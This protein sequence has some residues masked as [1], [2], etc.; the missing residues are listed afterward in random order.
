MENFVRAFQKGS[1]K[2][3]DLGEVKTNSITDDDLEGMVNFK[4]GGEHITVEEVDDENPI[5]KEDRNRLSQDLR[6]RHLQMIAICGVFGTGIF[7]SSGTVYSLTGAGGCFLAYALVAVVVGINQVAIAEVAALMPTSSAVVR[8]LE[9][10][11]DPA[12]GF[13]YGWI[14]WWGASMPG[15][16]SAAAV[17]V[18]YWTDINGAAWISIIIVLSFASNAYSMRVYGE[19]EFFFAILKLSLLLGLIIVSI[20]ITSGGGPNHEAIGFRYWRD[21]DAFLPFLTTGSLGRFAAFWKSLSSVV[22]SYGGVQSV[23]TLAS[24]VRYPR[25]SVFK[26]CKRIFFRVTILMILAAF[27]LTLI[28]SPEDKNI[29][30]GSGNAKS[31]PFV[32]AIKNAGI[33]ALPHIVNAVVLT[34]AFS[35]GNN[36]VVQGTRCLFAMAVKGQAPK[37]FLK[38]TKRGIPLNALLLVTLFMPLAFMSVSESAANVFNW[39]QN[40]TSSNLL[41]G[42]ILIGL[43]HVSMHRAMWAQGYT[44][45]DL[46]HTFPG[47]QYSGYVSG[48]ISLILLLTGGFTNFVHG[49]FAIAS[50]FSSYFVIPLTLVLFLF[51]KFFKKTKYLRPEDV[52]LNSLFMDVQRN[53]EPLEEPLRGWRLLTLL[54]N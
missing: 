41:L 29:T 54:W 51:W 48:V 45:A 9:H 52:D 23:P 43:N 39:F 42:W 6:S 22:Y 10:F 2:N 31:S 30:S 35:A 8:H 15:E 5:F 18:S 49:H 19:I 20:I 11:V 14:L 7:L 17:I 12:M 27:S 46:P 1:S 16:I 36:N 33:P 44:R 4:K 37:I 25:R 34:S 3:N 47:G 53:P 38:T 40:L 26:A 32:V 50:F 21:P 28:V 13:A 24:E